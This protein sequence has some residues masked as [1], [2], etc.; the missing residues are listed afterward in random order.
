M[1][2]WRQNFFKKYLEIDFHRSQDDC[3][4]EKEACEDILKTFRNKKTG[5]SAFRKP[6]GLKKQV[7]GRSENLR[8]E[9]KSLKT[10]QEATK[11]KKQNQLTFQQPW[12]RDG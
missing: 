4:D 7:C 11:L 6:L 5:L 12:T 2:A 3:E 9:K 1:A 10:F 8:T